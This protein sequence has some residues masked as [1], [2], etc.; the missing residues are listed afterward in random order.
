MIIYG[1]T[2]SQWKNNF[3]TWVKDNK[4]KVIAFVVWSIILLAI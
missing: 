4:R 2:P 1:E 3:L